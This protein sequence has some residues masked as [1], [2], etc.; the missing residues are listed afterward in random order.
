ML[1]AILN[2][3]WKQHPTKHWLYNHLLPISETIQTKCMGHCW[4]SKNELIS[5]ILPWTPS[6]R[7]ASV[8][9]PIRTY[10]Q[11]CCMNTGYRLEDL[12]EMMNDI[13][14]ARE[15]GESL[16][17]AQHDDSIYKS[18]THLPQAKCATR[19]VFKWSK[20]SELW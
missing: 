9:W 13:W 12:P 17:V 1:R 4:R 10:Q 7:H 8:G 19:L 20:G 18:P 11:Q 6:H 5:D 15:S 14:M 2:K 3:S 16:L